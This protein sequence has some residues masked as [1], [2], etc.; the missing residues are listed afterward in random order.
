MSDVVVVVVDLYRERSVIVVV[1]GAGVVGCGRM[2]WIFVDFSEYNNIYRLLSYL[3]L[4][5][6][7]FS[8]KKNVFF[9]SIF[10]FK[11]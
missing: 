9:L 7:Y 3:P 10:T 5:N 1:V 4:S 6:F 2:S 11:K 8:Q